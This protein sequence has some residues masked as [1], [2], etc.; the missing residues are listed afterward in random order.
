[1]EQVSFA[2]A[3]HAYANWFR[4]PFGGKLYPLLS[5]RELACFVSHGAFSVDAFFSCILFSFFHGIIG[6]F[7]LLMMLKFLC[8]HLFCTFF[9]D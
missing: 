8:A 7:Y 6:T 5:M 9:G 2:F 1:M 3:L 4:I